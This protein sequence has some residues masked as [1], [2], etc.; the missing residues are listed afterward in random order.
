MLG[1]RLGGAHQ[2]TLA[3]MKGLQEPKRARSFP[4]VSSAEM[5]PGVV[6]ALAG[7]SHIMG[8]STPRGSLAQG[9]VP[10]PA[11]SRGKNAEAMSQPWLSLTVS[12]GMLSDSPADPQAGLLSLVPAQTGVN[13]AQGPTSS[14]RQQLPRCSICGGPPRHQ[15]PQ[16]RSRP[17]CEPSIIPNSLR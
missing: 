7:S 1:T 14:L 4:H 15:R 17:T 3:S 11:I 2:Q 10:P 8:I 16:A 12:S 6:G 13:S 9:W 5:R